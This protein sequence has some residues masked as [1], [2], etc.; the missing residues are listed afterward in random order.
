MQ[1]SLV[2][3]RDAVFRQGCSLQGFQLKNAR[4]KSCFSKKKTVNQLVLS[5]CDGVVCLRV[6]VV[7][8]VSMGVVFGLL[9]GAS[10]LGVAVCLLRWYSALLAFCLSLFF[11]FHQASTT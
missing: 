4:I 7:I 10:M 5:I 2:A 1:L 3:S 11:S 9:I 8:V 6:G